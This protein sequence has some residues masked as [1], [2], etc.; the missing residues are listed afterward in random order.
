MYQKY[1]STLKSLVSEIVKF[2]SKE[3][4]LIEKSLMNGFLGINIVKKLF[5]YADI[6]IEEK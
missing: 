5:S 6:T 1:D 2:Y 3:F 4:D